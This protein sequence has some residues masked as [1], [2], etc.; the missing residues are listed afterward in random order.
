MQ[1]PNLDFQPADISVGLKKCFALCCFYLEPVLWNAGKVDDGLV[2]VVPGGVVLK[3]R[4]YAA[5]RQ[6]S[7]KFLN[8]IQSH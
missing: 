6:Y 4:R 8:A 2:E 1:V 5:V 3:R 7:I